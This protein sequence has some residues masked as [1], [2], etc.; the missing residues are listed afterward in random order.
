MLG[1]HDAG[2]PE[3][4]SAREGQESR[5]LRRQ[6]ARQ[7]EIGYEETDRDRHDPDQA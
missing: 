5:Q 7:Q 2:K 3:Q 6:Q 1:N 4:E